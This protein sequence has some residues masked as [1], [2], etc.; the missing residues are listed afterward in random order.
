MLLT[1]LGSTKETKKKN[2]EK[3]T[4]NISEKVEKF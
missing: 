4:G 3:F 1:F 2:L